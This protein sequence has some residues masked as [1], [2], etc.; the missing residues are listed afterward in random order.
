M[1]NPS[2]L[3]ATFFAALEMGSP[4]ERAAYL[5]VACAGDPDLRQRV[6]KML[7]AQDQAGSFLEQPVHGPVVTVDGHPIHEAPGAIIG[8]YKLIQQIGEGGM[9][10]VWMAQQTE[11]VRRLVALKLIKAGMDSK[12]VI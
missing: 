4:Q 7:A 1:N 9:G 8:Q 2:P 10:T 6:E 3:E 5:D 11:P 12:Q